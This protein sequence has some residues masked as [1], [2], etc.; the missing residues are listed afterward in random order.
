MQNCH[1]IGILLNLEIADRWMVNQSLNSRANLNQRRYC[2][3]LYVVPWTAIELK[4]NM[5]GGAWSSG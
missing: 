3:M 2:K 5:Q 4:L 1:T